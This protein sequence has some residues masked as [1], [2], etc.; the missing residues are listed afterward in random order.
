[1]LS[2]RLTF[3][4]AVNNGAV[5]IKIIS[6]TNITSTKGVTFISE[7]DFLF[8]NFFQVCYLNISFEIII[9]ISS[10]KTSNLFEI[11]SSIVLNLLK[12]KTE[13]MAATKPKAVAKMLLLYL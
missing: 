4:P 1:M 11:S 7:I 6:R 9:M 8:C 5:T 10:E 13:G 12:N 3:I 2:G